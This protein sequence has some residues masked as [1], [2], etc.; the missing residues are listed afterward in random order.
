MD[1]LYV[2]IFVFGMCCS[3]CIVEVV[4]YGVVDV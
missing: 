3:E 2:K 4:E 1:I